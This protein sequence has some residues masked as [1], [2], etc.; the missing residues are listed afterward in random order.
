M[1]KKSQGLALSTLAIAVLVIIIIVV[2]VALI[3]GYVGNWK[4]SVNISKTAVAKANCENFLRPERKCMRQ[5]PDGW[6]E[7]AI[8]AEDCEGYKCCEPVAA[9]KKK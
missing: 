9:E 1:L 7:V 4:S 6:V 3:I 2:I 8:T 5:C